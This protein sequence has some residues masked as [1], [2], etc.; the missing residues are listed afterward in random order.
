MS[1]TTSLS[2]ILAII[3]TNSQLSAQP[4]PDGI[5]P[6]DVGRTTFT[7]VDPA[8]EDRT[9]DVDVWYPVDPEDAVGVARASYDLIF[10][11]LESPLALDSPPVSAQGPRSLVVF[12][13]GSNGIRYQSYFLTEALASHGFVVAAPDHSGN[14][15]TDLVL[16]TEAPIEQ[17]ILDRPADISLT[18]TRMLERSAASGDF[19]AGSI[20]PVRIGV[21]G[22]SF[23]GYTALAM[24]GAYPGIPRD[25]RVLA[26]VPLAPATLLFTDT[27]LAAVDLPTMLLSGSLDVTTPVN[28]NTTRPWKLLSSFYRYRADI[29]G[30]GHQSFSD[31]CDI[32]DALLAV[33]IPPDFVEFIIGAADEGCGPD[34]I[35]SGEAHRLTRLY[36]AS[37]FK[38]FVAG[39]GG[40]GRY[41]SSRYTESESLPVDY[42]EYGAVLRPAPSLLRTVDLSISKQQ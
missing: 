19:F 9:F 27:D 14:T 12:S 40:Y 5:G 2:L 3:F 11:S 23:G 42:Y 33:G 41:L 38:L 6:W 36:T 22:H 15:A 35:D 10:A 31:I 26:I 13:H 17:I 25:P 28:P 39:E 21:T 24:A 8:R 30:G 34:L 18:I 37:F 7:V 32:T 29:V 4:A 20:D 1:R 16:G